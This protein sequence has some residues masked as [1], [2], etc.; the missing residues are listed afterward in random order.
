MSVPGRPPEPD[1]ARPGP[2][3]RPARAGAAAGRTRPS[4][5]ACEFCRAPLRKEPARG[6][7]RPQPATCALCG[8]TTLRGPGITICPECGHDSKTAPSAAA[9]A[10]WGARNAASSVRIPGWV[11][12][13]LLLV[14]PALVSFSIFFRAQRK[15]T[16]ADHIRQLKKVVEIYGIENG[17]FPADFAAVERRMAPA[18]KYLFTD[19]WENPITYVARKPRPYPVRG[20]HAPLRRV[21]DPLPRAERK[22][23]RR[24]RRRLD[25]KARAVSAAALPALPGY[26]VKRLLAKGGMAAV[27]AAVDTR[28][29]RPVALKRHPPRGRGRP[30]VPEPVRPRGEAPLAAEA[31]ERPRALRVRGGGGALPLDG[32][33]RRRDPSDRPRQP[34]EAPARAGALRRGRDAE[35]ARLR[36]RARHRPPRRQAAERHGDA[37]GR[38]EGRRLRHL[39]DEPDDAAHADR[40]RHRDA[41]VHVARAGD[42]HSPRRPLRPLLRRG[43]A[44]RGADGLESLPHRQPGDDAPADRRRGAPVPLPPRPVDPRRRRGLLREAPEE[45]PRRAVRER[46]GRGEGGRGGAGRDGRR[47]RG[48][49]LPV[50]HLRGPARGSPRGRPGSRRRAWRGRRGSRPPGRRRPRSS[51][52]PPSSR[53]RTTRREPTPAHSTERLCGRPGIASSA[54]PRVPGRPISRR[55]SGWSPTTR[56][57]SSRPPRRRRSIATSCA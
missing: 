32:A 24:G 47:G 39:E 17:G 43:D 54:G 31:P 45:A 40:E 15:A 35:G 28:S 12:A 56:R 6:A 36:S 27:Y 41:G 11:W 44:P 1:P 52:G 10:T 57:S 9:R 14:V 50:L 8:A 5:A 2:P 16:T 49:P 37:G 30:G 33:D 48:E 55:G 18:P 29:G 3:R 7:P 4:A 34:P 21:R 23:R 38:G 51:S 19:G 22:A 13:I 42:R 53:C 20:R 46:R 25:G 26:E